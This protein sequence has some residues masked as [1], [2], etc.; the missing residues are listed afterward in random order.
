MGTLP[1][2][3]LRSATFPALSSPEDAPLASTP[4]QAGQDLL[5]VLEDGIFSEVSAG[6]LSLVLE[7]L[8]VHR[9]TGARI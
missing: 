1:K 7:A 9:H 6:R 4:R 2:V 5:V 8:Q 3:F